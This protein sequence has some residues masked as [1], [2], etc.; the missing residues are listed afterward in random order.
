MLPTAP[1]GTGCIKQTSSRNLSTQQETQELV[2]QDVPLPP[3]QALHCCQE[4]DPSH[5]HPNK[6]SLP[7]AGVTSLLVIPDS[8]G[9][10]C[11]VYVGVSLFTKLNFPEEGAGWGLSLSPHPQDP[12]GHWQGQW[13]STP[14]SLPPPNPCP[15]NVCFLE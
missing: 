5:F 4:P 1:L 14:A 6:D 12:E 9:V 13:A 3:Q 10:G 15:S 7:I 11:V 8:S 2:P